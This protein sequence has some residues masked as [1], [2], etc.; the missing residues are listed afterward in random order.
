MN[1]PAVFLK[2]IDSMSKIRIIFD[3]K[4]K[5]RITRVCLPFD[6]GPSQKD[7]AIDRSEKYHVY[8]LDSPDGPHV[9]PIAPNNIIDIEVLN[10]KFDPVEYVNWEP[11]WI[12]KR[13][14]GIK[15]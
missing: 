2:A 7:G 10:E 5:G 11:K 4:S 14:W 13:N 9:I 3:S 15:S 6:F 1:N 12:D 8:D